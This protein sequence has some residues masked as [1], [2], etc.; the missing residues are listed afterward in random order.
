MAK[1]P[2]KNLNMP[3]GKKPKSSRILY[4][5]YIAIMLVLLFGMFDG[6][7][8]KHP[9]TWERFEKILVSDDYETITVV[10][11]SVAEIKIKDEALK[12]DPQYRDLK[13]KRGIFGSESPRLADFKGRHSIRL[14]VGRR[15]ALHL[16]PC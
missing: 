6:G 1:Q 13:A 7:G 10:N 8:S 4:I 12:R 15:T 11:Q 2:N 16:R 3:R 14:R 5:V 9:I